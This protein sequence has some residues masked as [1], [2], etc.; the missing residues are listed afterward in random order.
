MAVF[1][2]VVGLEI[3]RE[4]LAGELS[5]RKQAMLP[6]IAAVGG[7]LVPATIFFALNASGAGARGWGIPMPLISRWL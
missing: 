5:S 1:F 2:L 4:L 3:K 7:M 6:A